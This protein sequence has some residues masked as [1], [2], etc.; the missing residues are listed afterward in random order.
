MFE[1]KEKPST[2]ILSSEG[3]IRRLSTLQSIQLSD[4]QKIEI[5]TQ[6][7]GNFSGSA[8]DFMG[9]LVALPHFH[10]LFP[11][12]VNQQLTNVIRHEIVV[13][14]QDVSQMAM[15]DVMQ[16]DLLQPNMEDNF[17]YIPAKITLSMVYLDRIF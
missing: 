13:A 15:Y 5:I 4:R 2:V 11:M 3:Y 7:F 17:P 12:T 6:I 1:T 16:H 9:K 14:T 10:L 8:R